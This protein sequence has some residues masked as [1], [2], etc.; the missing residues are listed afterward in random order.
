MFFRHQKQRDETN[1]ENIQKC[2][3]NP[4]FRQVV[5]KLLSVTVYILCHPLV[6]LAIDLVVTP[7]LMLLG[8]SPRF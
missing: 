5:S 6:P 4:N 7:A 1:G 2:Y 3:K 8:L